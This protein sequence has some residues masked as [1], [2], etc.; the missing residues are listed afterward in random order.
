MIPIRASGIAFARLTEVPPEEI[1]AH[2]SDP[3]IA[4]HMPLLASPWDCDTA[5]RFAAAKE[6]RRR[7]DGLGHLAILHDGRYVGWGGFQKEG[8]EWDFGLV[9]KPD[10]FG[11]GAAIT[12][13]AF[14]FARIDP[15]IPSVTFL[16][17][18]SRRSLRGLARLGAHC[19]GEVVHAGAT[20][21]RFRLDTSGATGPIAAGDLQD[22]TTM[23]VLE[24]CAPL[25]EPG[26]TARP[27]RAVSAVLG[28][29]RL[30]ETRRSCRADGRSA[31]LRA[32]GG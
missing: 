4:R 1:A 31:A 32:A 17:A 19:E 30:C 26:R 22:K 14:A 9:L 10:A 8:A 7:G 27:A 29:D 21:L 16:L 20:F 23:A 5:R 28:A 18:P 13:A 25:G 6:E 24:G 15:R 3:R 11:L 2:M 12:R